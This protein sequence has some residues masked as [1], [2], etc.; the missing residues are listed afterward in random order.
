VDEPQADESYGSRQPLKE[1][2]VNFHLSAANFQMNLVVGIRHAHFKL[3]V[4]S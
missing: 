4:R 2:F 3:I 1:N